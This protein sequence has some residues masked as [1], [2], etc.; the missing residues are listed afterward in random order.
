ME[1]I[2]KPSEIKVDLHINAQSIS[3]QVPAQM[4]LLRFLRDRM[5]LMGTKD[6][7]STGHCGTCTVIINGKSQRAC[8]VKM[9]AL[10]GA[11]IET[12][13]GLS[14]N[15]VLH[16]LQQAFIDKG[17]VQCGFCIPGVLMTSKALLDRNPHPNPAEIK[18]DL[19]QNRNLCRCTGYVK[20]I[21]AIQL[22]A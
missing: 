1:V 20:I 8:L 17:D 15:G 9:A 13:E 12:V 10:D 19:T 21:E 6:G 7:C 18:K 3:V 11:R 14:K 22:A 4:S 16:P 2:A 5:G